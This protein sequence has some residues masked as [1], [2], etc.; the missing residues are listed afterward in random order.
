MLK[1]KVSTFLSEFA[2]YWRKANIAV[3]LSGGIDS[4]ATLDMVSLA[5]P[6]SHITCY[7]AKF[8]GYNKTEIEVA[9]EIAD[10]FELIEVPVSNVIKAMPKIL[11]DYQRPQYNVWPYWLC[12]KAEKDG[13]RV[14][15]SGEGVD[16]IFGYMDRSY[17]QGWTSQLAWID[18]MWRHCATINRLLYVAPFLESERAV[19]M[20]QNRPLT[21]GYA[22]WP[23]KWEFKQIF[24]S[25][26][27]MKVKGKTF[28]SYGFFRVCL[29][30][31]GVDHLGLSDQI[32]S[33][34]T[35][36]VLQCY[37]AVA[38]LQANKENTDEMLNLFKREAT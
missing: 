38:F 15:F 22:A 21:T 2:K 37:A 32:V 20:K 18:P 11:K 33:N 27:T 26:R 1:A 14:L 24:N 3:S 13:M 10:P 29:D 16:E 17:F 9:R 5:F 36:R 23:Y 4:A 7:I 25:P 6:K 28:P 30:E 12:R 19:F 8:K 35:T 31:M 34:M